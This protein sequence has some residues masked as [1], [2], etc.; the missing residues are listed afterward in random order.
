MFTHMYLFHTSKQIA[1]LRDLRKGHPAEVIENSAVE[2]CK[3]DKQMSSD[4][5]TVIKSKVIGLHKQIQQ[6]LNE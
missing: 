2:E 1:R 6:T 3:L 4:M 5:T